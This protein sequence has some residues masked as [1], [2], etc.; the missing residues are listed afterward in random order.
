M[1]SPLTTKSIVNKISSIS[2]HTLTHQQHEN[3]GD[4]KS[5]IAEST[6]LGK[7]KFS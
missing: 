5:Q 7:S 4:Q 1:K 3:D 6:N 2:H